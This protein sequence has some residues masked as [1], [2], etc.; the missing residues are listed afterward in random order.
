MRAN[1][2]QRLVLMVLLILSFAVKAEQ[3]AQLSEPDKRISMY[4]QDV[5]V[6]EALQQLALLNSTN[7]VISDSVSGHVSVKLQDV[8]WQ[9]AFDA[10]LSLKAL[11]AEKQG[12]ILLVAPENELRAQEK[13][14]LESL[15]QAI[16]L[17]PLT[18]DSF[19]I[20]HTSAE[21]LASVIDG[22]KGVSL[23]SSRGSVTVDSR[24]NTLLIKDIAENIAAIQKMI[25]T[26]DRPVKQ[27]QIEARIVSMNEGQLDELG[28]RWGVS[29]DRGDI[30]AG[31]TIE[32]VSL[33]DADLSDRLNV[34]FAA[35]SVKAASAAFQLATLG[36]GVLLDLELSALQA[37]SKA[38]II[39]SPRLITTN[40]TPAYIEQGT[41]IPYL[42]PGAND[43]TSIS[44]KKAVL[45]LEVTPQ[46]IENNQLILDLLISQDRPGEVVKSGT[47][48]AVAIDTQRV[49]TQVR[50][51]NEQTLVLG[52]VLHYSNIRQ[53]DKV[54]LLGDIPAIGHLF[55]TKY[56][57][58][59][60][61]ELLIFVTPK[62]IISGGNVE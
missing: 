52:G 1:I 4:F 23:L 60:K 17:E 58:I 6:T 38:E 49:K 61:R 53:T 55:K 5:P 41:E 54:P 44:F 42:E 28:V 10:I 31:G 12:D 7:L 59:T 35:T 14:R 2:C 47:G 18:M 33:E 13:L 56:E 51:N 34:S 3:G 21:N 19:T 45:S 40:K 62:V 15:E 43:A 8:P 22:E 48:E 25:K 27:V 11:Q 36:Q 9:Q 37:E 57:K 32:G 39:S 29:S 16:L 46:I 30:K 50:L 26:L 24:T 20:K